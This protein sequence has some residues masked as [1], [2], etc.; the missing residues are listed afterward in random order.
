MGRLP[1]DNPKKN[2][3][4]IRLT[5]EELENIDFIAYQLD[6][7]RTQVILDS[8]ESRYFQLCEYLEENPQRQR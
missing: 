4:E 7:S 5:D 6:I 8:I 3:F 2:R 1:S